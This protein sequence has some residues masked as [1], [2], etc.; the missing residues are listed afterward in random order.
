MEPRRTL[1]RAVLAVVVASLALVPPAG[2]LGPSEPRPVDPPGV[3]RLLQGADRAG[4]A[5]G[6]RW[7]GIADGLLSWLGA[8]FRTDPATRVPAPAR[9]KLD[10]WGAREATGGYPI[11]V[12]IR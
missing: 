4:S 12:R 9:Q 2:A 1:R 8:A 11:R 6:S 3:F 10:A 7:V 5:W